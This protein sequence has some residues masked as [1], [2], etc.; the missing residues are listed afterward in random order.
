[1]V[2][3][4]LALFWFAGLA[5]AEVKYDLPLQG[6]CRVG[7]FMP[8]RVI[9]FSTGD[10]LKLPGCLEVRVA[11][12]G[13]VPNLVLDSS[14]PLRGLGDDGRLILTT[15]DRAVPG[16]VRDIR[17]RVNVGDLD[18]LLAWEC[19][20]EIE[21]GE[22]DLRTAG[23][24]FV[25]RAL[26]LGIRLRAVSA[27]APRVLQGWVQAGDT[28]VLEPRL[29]LRSRMEE[30][31]YFPSASWHPGRETGARQRVVLFAAVFSVL[32]VGASLLKLRAAVVVI[33]VLCLAASGAAVLIQWRWS[34]VVV[35]QGSIRLD[36][37]QFSQLDRYVYHRA[38]NPSPIRIGLDRQA[39]IF[40]SLSQ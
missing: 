17:L 6:W 27:S 35:M 40:A 2:W 13:I 16:D 5:R 4:A 30:D 37:A 29:R 11:A 22:A 18:P 15:V 12:T 25:D 34:N 39:P 7:Q 26:A 28:W 21:L 3:G 19:A 9:A 31:V 24:D 1:M 14:P 10:V 23:R 33:G 8:V 38:L 32:V 20:D 36:G